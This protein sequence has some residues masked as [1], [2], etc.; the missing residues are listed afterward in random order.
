MTMLV[1]AI[2]T[3]Y[4][5]TSS[6]TLFESNIRTLMS[7]HTSHTASTEELTLKPLDHV[8]SFAHTALTILLLISLLSFSA[9]QIRYGAALLG[10]LPSPE[11]T[12][13]GNI[14]NPPVSYSE[15]G[16]ISI[17]AQY[18]S[19][20]TAASDP[21]NPNGQTST[22]L[23]FNDAWFDNDSYDYNHELATSCSTLTAICN[24]ESQF[25]GN[26]KDAIPYAEK[27]LG[28][29]GF[30][31]IQ[32]DSYALRSDLL[33][34]MA[35]LFVGSHD[36]ATYVLASKTL[37]GSHGEPDQ[38][39]IFVGIRGSYGTEWLSNLKLHNTAGKPDHLGYALAEQELAKAL[40]EYIRKLAITPENT[41][42]L[43]T[44]HSRGGAIANLLAAD[45]SNRAGGVSLLAHR[46]NIYTYTFASPT[47]TRISDCHDNRYSNIFNIINPSDIVP[48][49]PFS[50]WGFN[51][52]GTTL[53]LPGVHS[54][55]FERSYSNMQAA[56]TRNTGYANPCSVND[57]D[58][59]T[60]LGKRAGEKI[61]TQE[62]LFSPEGIAF[63]AQSLFSHDFSTLG[64]AHHPDTYIAWM[65]SIKATDLAQK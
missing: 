19:E 62:S 65:Q 13:Y 33:D 49:L 2:I 46:D 50:S 18:C 21:A 9:L 23:S 29:L 5:A 42:L 38:T 17:A 56:Y 64:Y 14:A 27:A 44:G 60:K 35:I 15:N 51:R 26:I 39:L 22:A 30:S 28:S 57:L 54:H 45:L 48:D 53:M 41:K 6:G 36:V 52:Y 7:K 8:R 1:F 10:F 24:S 32:T 20:V 43:I 37:P 47:T 4:T 59:L 25:Y 31:R 16:S 12:A 55:S 58:S 34:Q 3:F 63:V 40:Q 61:R 11:A